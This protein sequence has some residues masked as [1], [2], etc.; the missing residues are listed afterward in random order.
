MA[1]EYKPAAQSFLRANTRLFA[2]LCKPAMHLLLVLLT[3]TFKSLQQFTGLFFFQSIKFAKMILCYY[4][5]SSLKTLS[6]KQ[7]ATIQQTRFGKEYR[8]SYVYRLYAVGVREIVSVAL[9]RKVNFQKGLK[10]MKKKY[11]LFIYCQHA[12]TYEQKEKQLVI[13]TNVWMYYWIHE[14]EMNLLAC[15]QGTMVQGLNDEDVYSYQFN[16]FI[17]KETRAMRENLNSRML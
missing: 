11:Q 10:W 15:S 16:V 7:N 17:R 12:V 9:S 1:I 8:N 6:K 5:K 13:Q 14:G 2:A 4:T 3:C